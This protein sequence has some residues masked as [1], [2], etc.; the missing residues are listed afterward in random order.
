MA[1]RNLILIVG[2]GSIGRQHARVIAEGFPNYGI[3]ILRR[4]ESQTPA[5]DLPADT[6]IVTS[7]Q[8]AIA[9]KPFA[10]VVCNPAPW[11]IETSL[12]LAAIGVHLLIEKPISHDTADVQMLIE[13]CREQRCVLQVGYCLRFDPGLA[14]LKQFIDEGEIGEPLMLRAETG[15][16]LPDWRLG[17]DYRQSVSAQRRLGG[18]ALLELSHELDYAEWLLGPAAAVSARIERLGDLDIDV[19]DTAEIILS[20][21]GNRIASIHL[22]FLQRQPVRTCKVAGTTGTVVWDAIAKQVTLYRGSGDDPVRV[23][24]RGTPKDRLIRQMAHF[25]SCIRDN[26]P[27]L[28]G[29]AEGLRALRIVDAVRRSSDNGTTVGI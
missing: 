16:Y 21:S 14:R 2:L 24:V 10:A 28:V 17:A 23:E 3:C 6:R 11:H 22:D 4:P 1:D 26:T 9:M 20:F 7:L 25:L 27:P 29:G 8:E 5:G 12:E 15:Q 19:E 13:R 18:G